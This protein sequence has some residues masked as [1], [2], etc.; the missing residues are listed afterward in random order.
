MFKA[1]VAEDVGQLRALLD[2]DADVNQLNP[3]G[4]T[5]LELA[6]DRAKSAAA[7][8]LRE[9]GPRCLLKKYNARAGPELPDATAGGTE[10]IALE[11]QLRHPSCP[12]RRGRLG[13]LR[14]FLC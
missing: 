12:G 14:I 13:A 8:C 10:L 3:A 4:L 9:H 2:A 7:A 5:P 6:C 11:L 1:V